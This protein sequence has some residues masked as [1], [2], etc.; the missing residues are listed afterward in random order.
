MGEFEYLFLEAE[1]AKNDL[2]VPGSNKV[3][4]EKQHSYFYMHIIA[5]VCQC[6][7]MPIIYVYPHTQLEVTNVEEKYSKGKE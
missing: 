4:G 2:R 5:Q 1:T 6:K 3:V 7:Q